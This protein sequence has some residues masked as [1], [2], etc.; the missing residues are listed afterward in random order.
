MLTIGS[1]VIQR[2]SAVVYHSTKPHLIQTRA[3]Q[4]PVIQPIELKPYAIQLP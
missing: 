4:L 3:I 1:H 2:H